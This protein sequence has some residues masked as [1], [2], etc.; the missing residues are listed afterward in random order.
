M[1]FGMMIDLSIRPFALRSFMLKVPGVFEA[2][3]S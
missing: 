3:F 2:P 1:I